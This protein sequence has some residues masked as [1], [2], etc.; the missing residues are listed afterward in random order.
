MNILLRAS[1]SSDIPFLREMLYEAVFWRESNK[2]PSFEEGLSYP[3]VSN[4]L[5]EWGKREGDAAVIAT[6]NSIPVGAAWYR[7]WT[8]NDSIRGYIDENTPVLAI[9]VHCNYRHQ[10]IGKKM[11]DW[12]I[13]Y[14]S[15]YSI[16]RISLCVSKDNYA[17]NLY[18][19]QGFIE[20]AD[21]GDSFIM[22][23]EI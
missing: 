4:A 23:R 16:K 10:G 17:I 9:G 12:L 21:T 8:D 19:Q 22:V 14:A 3:D 5:A 13:D 18:R 20:Y 15:K 11:I 1:Q 7:F 2:K 6:I